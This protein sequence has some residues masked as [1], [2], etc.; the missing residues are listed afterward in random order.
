MATKGGEAVDEWV[1]NRQRRETET[2]YRHAC[3]TG[4]GPRGARENEG[5]REEGRVVGGA[6]RALWT[7]VAAHPLDRRRRSLGRDGEDPQG[8]IG[9]RYQGRR[10][11]EG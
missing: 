10:E 3:A 6:F 11:R 4:R 1:E 5:E 9:H 8:K 7:A 2:W